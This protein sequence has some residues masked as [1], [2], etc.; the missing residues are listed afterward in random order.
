MKCEH[1]KKRLGFFKRLLDF[2]YKA[3]LI[4]KDKTQSIVY[5]CS[6]DCIK[7]Y[8]LENSYFYASNQNKK[9]I[10]YDKKNS[11]YSILIQD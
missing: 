4:N 10:Y 7:K 5:F 6:H 1:C 3:F 2:Y 9:L 8:M 11:E